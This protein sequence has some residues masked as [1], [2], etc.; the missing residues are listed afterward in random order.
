MFRGLQFSLTWRYTLVTVVALFTIELVTLLIFQIATAGN[1]LLPTPDTR[2]LETIREKILTT[3][4][5]QSWLDNFST[6]TF[7]FSDASGKARLIFY[8]FPDR[9]SQTLYLIDSNQI[10]LAQTPT[11]NA[12]QLGTRFDLASLKVLPPTLVQQLTQLPQQPILPELL[13]ASPQTR[14]SHQAS[15]SIFTYSDASKDRLI[16]ILPVYKDQQLQRILIIVTDTTT[17]SPL[18]AGFFLIA[19]LSLVAFTVAAVIVGALF[20]I[21]TARPLTQRIKRLALITAAWGH[22][23][24]SQPIHDSSP[25]EIGQLASHLDTV[26]Q[27]LHSLLTT[28]QQLTALEERNR[29]ARDLHDSVKQQAFAISMNLGT[30]QLLWEKNPQEAKAKLQTAID[31]AN[32]TQHELTSLIQTLRPA[33]LESQSLLPA[34]RELLQTWEA[35]TTII[36]LYSLPEQIQLPDETQ[37]TIFRVTQEALANISKHSRATKVN[38]VLE[39]NKDKI[40][41]EIRDNGQGFNTKAS[42]SGI[43]LRSMRERV[44]AV[45]GNFQIASSKDGT[46]IHIEFNVTNG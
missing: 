11:T 25:D 36:T 15:P 17:S 18:S 12:T 4:E 39:L 7:N 32:Q 24:F 33:Q 9:S 3:T 6:P 13:N 20:G 38:F 19:A 27:Q 16:S 30:A 41:L 8:N 46:T 1:T 22:G 31:L 5:P 14:F 37:Q 43:G 42:Q 40:L 26:S 45:N 10:L 35:Q 2:A 21:F 34:L 28:R 44:E 23:D 29:L